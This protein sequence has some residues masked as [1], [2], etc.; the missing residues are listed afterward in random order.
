MLFLLIGAAVGAVAGACIAHA[1][2]ENDRQS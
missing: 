1:S 2:N